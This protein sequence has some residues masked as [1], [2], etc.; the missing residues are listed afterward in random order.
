MQRFRYFVI[1]FDHRR[2]QAKAREPLV[3]L[4]QVGVEKIV[5]ALISDRAIIVGVLVDVLAAPFQ[6]PF[7]H[8]R[9]ATE[10]KIVGDGLRRHHTVS[11][12]LSVLNEK[13][14]PFYL[15]TCLSSKI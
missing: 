9:V 7:D 6:I 12:S 3:V 1:W 11:L 15:A 4:L 10:R 14:L 13:L 8:A 5:V 2:W